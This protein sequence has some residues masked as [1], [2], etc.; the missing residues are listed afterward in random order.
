MKTENIFM[1]FL[2]IN[3][4]KLRSIKLYDLWY[5]IEI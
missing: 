1:F 4:L 3:E 2:Q 5:W